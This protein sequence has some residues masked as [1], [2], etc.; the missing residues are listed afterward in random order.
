MPTNHFICMKDAAALTSRFREMR[1]QILDPHYQ[2]MN[3]MP[4]CETFDRAA[5]DQVL[6]QDGCVGIRIYMGMEEN[7]QLV[8][9]VVGVNENDED[10]INSTTNSEDDNEIFE[11]GRR[12]PVTCPPP[13]PI[14]S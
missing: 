4:T 8:F 10:M 1:E 12:C 6:Q 11:N 14:N 5:F 9:V 7:N 3:V 13:S 2:G